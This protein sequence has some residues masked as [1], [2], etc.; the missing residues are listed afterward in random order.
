[1]LI[2]KLEDLK[3]GNCFRS[4]FIGKDRPAGNGIEE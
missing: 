2:C 4:E 1:M 3:S